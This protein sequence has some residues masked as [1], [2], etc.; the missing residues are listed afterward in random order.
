MTERRV[1]ATMRTFAQREAG[2]MTRRCEIAFRLGLTAS[3][4]P[5]GCRLARDLGEPLAAG[6]WG[7]CI[8]ERIAGEQADPMVLWTLDGLRCELEAARRPAAPHAPPRESERER[9]HRE[10]LGRWSAVA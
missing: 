6:S 9:R 2:T 4:P 10:A 7:P 3:C 5:G 8:V 1:I